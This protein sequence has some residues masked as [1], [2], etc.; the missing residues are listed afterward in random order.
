MYEN[1]TMNYQTL[2]LIADTE[3]SLDWG[4]F[5][6]EVLIVAIST[7]ENDTCDSPTFI[8][9]AGVYNGSTQYA[10]NYFTTPEEGEH[11]TGQDIDGPDVAYMMLMPSGYYI[12][13]TLEGITAT[14]NWNTSMYLLT[15]CTDTT[16]CLMGADINTSA[17]ERLTYYN[18]GAEQY[19]WLV[20]DGRTDTSGGIYTLNVDFQEYYGPQNTSCSDPIELI[21]GN[22]PI[23][24]DLSAALNL[25]DVNSGTCSSGGAGPDLVYSLT[26]DSYQ[27]GT[28]TLSNLLPENFEASMYVTEECSDL[29]GCLGY[30]TIYASSD[31]GEISVVNQNSQ[32]KTFYLIVSGY[33][34][35]DAGTFEVAATVVQLDPPPA[36]NTCEGAI[37][38][39]DGVTPG[40]ENRLDG[41]SNVEAFNTYSGGG[42]CTT[43]GTAGKDLVYVMNLE[44]FHRV[45]LHLENL[46]TSYDMFNYLLNRLSEH[47]RLLRGVLL[48]GNPGM[49]LPSLYQP[50]T[51]YFV[52]DGSYA[53]DE[54]T[55]DLVWTYEEHI[56]PFL[57]ESCEA[58]ME[59]PDPET[60]EN[61]VEGNLSEAQ[62]D[63]NAQNWGCT[64]YGGG[65]GNDLVFMTTL[66]PNEGAAIEAGTSGDGVFYVVVGDDCA[67]DGENE[68]IHYQDSPDENELLYINDTGEQ[69]N[70]FMFVDS[71]YTGTSHAGDFYIEVNVGNYTP[72]TNATC[73]DPTQ[74]PTDGTPVDGT[75]SEATNDYTAEDFGCL[76]TAGSGNDVVYQL[77]IGNNEGV[78][79]HMDSIGGDETALYI[80]TGDQ[81]APGETTQCLYAAGGQSEYDFAYPNTSGQ[82]VD[83][84][85]HRGQ[86]NR[87]CG[88]PSAC[89]QFSIPLTWWKAIPA[90]RTSISTTSHR[91]S[92]TTIRGLRPT[93]PAV[94]LSP[95]TMWFTKSTSM[96]IRN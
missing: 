85:P 90:I 52:V 17:A 49:D 23:P 69:T 22:D 32:P 78:S 2:T 16:S 10:T 8:S 40:D 56:P 82:P 37:D 91:R 64:S 19:L 83:L 11:C 92:P 80:V 47:Y 33:N 14:S 7:P 74:L 95:V 25:Y 13:A 34:A 6:I 76:T 65:N 58:P 81:C 84:Y 50:V 38:L 5:V 72:L 31:T 18:T 3:D 93:L 21:P 79:I 29:L 62:H 9:E 15:D 73:D 59:L 46:S 35:D 75:L 63:H 77:T 51:Y 28:F 12:D 67:P 39:T 68:C 71:Y 30:K 26:L 27:E 4:P 66:E 44:P 43:G 61:R 20:V 96:P 60:G 88:F 36:N 94:I 89:R 86:R 54:G 24:G 41:Q 55:F 53:T 1:D 48:H 70:V 45:V 42:S 87:F 57:N